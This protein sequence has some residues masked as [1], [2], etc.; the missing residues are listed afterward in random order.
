MSGKHKS[1][2]TAGE[3][4]TD[5]I[6]IK[7]WTVKAA[8][9]KHITFRYYWSTLEYKP[10]IYQ[11]YFEAGII[12]MFYQILLRIAM[13]NLLLLFYSAWD[14]AGQNI[15]YNTHQVVKNSLLL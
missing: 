15:Y 4:P 13:A 10:Y 7:T 5:G 1:K 11:W 6:S 9:N 14:F 2:G 12:K 8:E 3:Q